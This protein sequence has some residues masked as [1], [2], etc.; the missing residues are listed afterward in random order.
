MEHHV[1]PENDEFQDLTVSRYVR[2]AARTDQKEG[3]EA[4]SFV[5][6]GLVGETGTLLSEAKKKQRDRAS[7]LGYAGGVV[8]ELGDVLWY[9]AA[10]ARRLGE[11][12]WWTEM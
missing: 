4:M 8:E 6:L 5:L 3:S 1:T 12:N 11:R 9:L 10:V 2:D 7:Y